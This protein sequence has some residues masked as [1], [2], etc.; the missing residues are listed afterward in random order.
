MDVQSRP[1]TNPSPFRDWVI[2]HKWILALT[3]TSV[4]AGGA[5]W[6]GAFVFAGEA[7]GVDLI[8]HPIGYTGS[9]NSLTLEV[10]IKPSSLVPAGAALTDMEIPVQNNIAIWNQLQPIV[11]N[12]LLGGASNLASNEIDF[13]SVA[14]HELGHCI[15]LAHVN[16]ASESGLSGNDTNYTNATDG[17]D[18]LFNINAGVDGIRGTSDDIRGDDVNLH[19]FR[20]DSNDP[21]QLPLPTPVDASTYDVDI[22]SL[23][24]GHEFAANLD[25]TAAGTMGH[26]NTSTV[27]TEAVMQ[28][29]SYPDEDQWR[30]TADGV[31][32]ILLAASGA[33]ETAGTADDYILNLTYGGISSASSCDLTMEFTSMGGLAFC[34]YG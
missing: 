33:D 21:G 16:A 29:T 26:P 5:A 12:A 20:T 18:N 4:L 24:A 6:A 11:G 22:L 1:L 25:R 27:R 28:Q 13:E 30:L 7:N 8:T 23:P 9:Q 32:I 10:C 19:W 3:V 15:G 14:L 31:A 17:I 34:A 2:R